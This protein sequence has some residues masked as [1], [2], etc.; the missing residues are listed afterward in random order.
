VELSYTRHGVCTG[1]KTVTAD[2]SSLS[3]KT[4][5]S[6]GGPTVDGSMQEH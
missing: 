5:Q 6:V 3:A 1:V 4:A 2:M